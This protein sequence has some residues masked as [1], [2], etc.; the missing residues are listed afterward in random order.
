MVTRPD[1]AQEL[2]RAAKEAIK[3]FSGLKTE[4]ET[5]AK[6]KMERLLSEMKLVTQDEFDAV[7]D[8]AA[9]ARTEQER[10]AA[11]IAVL[12]A[13]LGIVPVEAKP[14]A[15]RKKAAKTESR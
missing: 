2:T 6:A 1:I 12:E 11:R 9:K 8:M 4:A 14:K 10:L 5:F 7:R 3:T 13:K 15:P